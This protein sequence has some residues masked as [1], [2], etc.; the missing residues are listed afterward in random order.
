M[1]REFCEQES[2]MAKSTAT[3]TATAATPESTAE[4]QARRAEEKA[5]REELID[6]IG[7]GIA[8]MKL[9]LA[10]QEEAEKEIRE[11]VGVNPKTGLTKAGERL[12]L[13]GYKFLGWEVSRTPRTTYS[14]SQYGASGRGVLG[15]EEHYMEYFR[16]TLDGKDA[17]F[18][19][20]DGKQDE[21]GPRCIGRKLAKNALDRLHI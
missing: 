17:I 7:P 18:V 20:M 14:S 8:R 9:K 5:H 19:V 6:R 3:A 2:M 4:E 15:Y 11:K 21:A 13:K 10:Q 12:Q 16:G 1:E